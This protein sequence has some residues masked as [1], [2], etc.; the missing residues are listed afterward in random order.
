M[1]RR[2][3]A[4][5]AKLVTGAGAVQLGAAGVALT[6]K[7]LGKRPEWY[8]NAV[9]SLEQTLKATGKYGFI[10][11]EA[12]LNEAEETLKRFVNLALVFC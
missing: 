4:V 9:K 7:E 10:E 2:A 11:S 6:D 1:L 3:A 12:K 8:Q 5:A